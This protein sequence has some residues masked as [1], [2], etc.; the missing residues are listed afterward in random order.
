MVYL[1]GV[2]GLR[3]SE[4]IGLRVGAIDFLRRSVD[5]TVTVAEVEGLLIE[6]A[7]LSRRHPFRRY[8]GDGEGRAEVRQEIVEGLAR[9][10]DLDDVRAACIADDNVLDAVVVAYITWRDHE[11]LTVW[12][13]DEDHRFALVEGWIHL[14][15][16]GH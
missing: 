8:K 12:R 2:L 5:V 4:V 7:P 10:V 16:E 14:P 6:D 3:W 9:L 11:K 1:A 13:S 15:C